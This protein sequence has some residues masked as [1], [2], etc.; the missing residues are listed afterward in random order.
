MTRKR[1]TPVHGALAGRSEAKDSV[2]SRPEA[3]RT[4]TARPTEKSGESPGPSVKLKQKGWDRKT[5]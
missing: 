2:V 5:K 4:L 3:S 1:R